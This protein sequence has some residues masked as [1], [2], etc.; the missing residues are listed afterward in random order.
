MNEYQRGILVIGAVILLSVGLNAPTVQI[1]QG[2]IYAS[3]ALADTVATVVDWRTTL[4]YSFMT[5]VV[6]ALLW[7][8]L[9][10]IGVQRAAANQVV[11][12]VTIR[13]ASFELTDKNGKCRLR[14]EMREDG[15]PAVGLIGEDDTLQTWL[16]VDTNGNLVQ[17]S[18][19][20]DLA[21]V[22]KL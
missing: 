8:A 3:G 20:V 22:R 6:I 2:T 13:A 19:E 5:L 7:M 11:T 4:T 18:E 15:N 12:A 9:R 17:T 16:A 1:H 14:L 10:G 21:G